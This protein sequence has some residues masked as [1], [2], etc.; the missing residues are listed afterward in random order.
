[1]II[2]QTIKSSHGNVPRSS[3]SGLLVVSE[4]RGAERVSPDLRRCQR[5]E[6]KT[7]YTRISMVKW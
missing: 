6:G 3:G 4:R 2:A 5:D 1:M 7:V